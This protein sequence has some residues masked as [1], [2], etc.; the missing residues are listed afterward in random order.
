MMARYAKGTRVCWNWG[1]GTGSGDV[2]EIFTDRVCLKIKGSEVV[3]DA[4]PECPA[5]LIVQE[6]GDEVLKSESELEAS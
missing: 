5:Y 3:R 1:R 6:D 2:T 4:S